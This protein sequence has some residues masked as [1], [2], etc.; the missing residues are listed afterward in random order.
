[1]MPLAVK[2]V[3]AKVIL[4]TFLISQQAGLVY[5][6][7]VVSAQPTTNVYQ[8]T[9]GTTIVEISTAN[10]QGLSHNKFLDYNV[11]S[12]GVVLNN[13]TASGLTHSSE[14]AGSIPANQYSVKQA[15][16]ILNEV[17]TTNPSELE[18]YTEV[19]GKNADVVV[20]NPNGIT[21]NGCGFINTNQVS[22]TTGNPMIDGTGALNGFDV[23]NG[24]I[25]IGRDGADL[26]NQQK[27]NIVARKIV[28]D[29]HIVMD[30]PDEGSGIEPNGTLQLV[31]G[32]N[33]WDYETGN[34]VE[35]SGDS[36]TPDYGIDSTV[37]GGMYAGRITFKATEDGVGVKMLGNAASSSDDFVITSD[38]IIEIKSKIKSAKDINI[39][40][41]ANVDEVI[42]S[43]DTSG[44]SA[45]NNI[46]INA[47]NSDLTLS[48]ST[49]YAESS[50]DID[51]K[52]LTDA[53]S[54]EKQRVANTGSINIDTSGNL[55][56]SNSIWKSSAGSLNIN[57]NGDVSTDTVKVVSDSASIISDTGDIT[58]TNSSVETEQNIT[59]RSNAGDVNLL[60]NSGTNPNDVFVKSINGNIDIDA[61]NNLVNTGL[62][63]SV[64]G[65]LNINS[66]VFNNSNNIQSN[67]IMT[68]DS[69]TINNSAVISTLSGLNINGD[70]AV[71]DGEVK[72]SGNININLTDALTV[73]ILKSSQNLTANSNTLTVNQNGELTSE[74]SLTLTHND[75][76]NSALIHS[77]NHAEITANNALTSSGTIQS[78]DTMTL[79]FN[80]IDNDGDIVSSSNLRFVGSSADL[81]GE[82]ESS[83]NIDIQLTDALTLNILKSSQNIN[84]TSTGLTVGQNGELSADG[85]LTLSHDTIQNAGKIL[86]DI[87][88]DITANNTLSNTGDIQSQGAMTIN[89][90]SLDNDSVISSLSDLAFIGNN[91]VIGG[92]VRSTG[93]I[94]INLADAL[95]V[96]I[97]KSSQ[98]ITANTREPAS[99]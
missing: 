90:G 37:F 98:N 59:L 2:K 28:V 20:A 91:A 9:N 95:T 40:A 86:S 51:T 45:D 8:S 68:I 64:N 99:K 18:G 17:V 61:S 34:V 27:F 72:A 62:I 54:S 49:I 85:I 57:S 83:G 76:Q 50:I 35:T 94:N 96:N 93:N 82:V 14:L 46:V 81:A 13:T 67:G 24:T 19:V 70:D 84:A 30:K 80:S 43:E 33:Q 47:V 78:M 44:L 5:G 56:T 25:S 97:L 6:G 1:M 89:F 92:E 26:T 48:N 42:I 31:S 66:N 15:D 3:T 29:G 71:L 11:D 4:Y 63:N 55:T 16:I 22:L 36:N 53:N 77:E 10:S 58:L 32:T 73:N 75:I 52:N 87:S 23:Q 79:N 39:I 38:G 65:L 60:V 88:A 21:C 69:S 41:E 7:D 12:Q 74:A